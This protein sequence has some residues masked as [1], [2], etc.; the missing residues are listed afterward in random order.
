MH[1][2]PLDISCD[3]TH[4]TPGIHILPECGADI[5]SG[6]SDNRFGSQKLRS[7]ISKRKTTLRCLRWE[8]QGRN[9][10]HV[11]RWRFVFV[12]EYQKQWTQ[13]ATSVS[14]FWISFS[15]QSKNSPN[16]HVFLIYL[17]IY[18]Y[19]SEVG[20]SD[21]ARSTPPPRN[22]EIVS[23]RACVRQ[24]KMCGCKFNKWAHKMSLV[25][26]WRLIQHHWL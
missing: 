20:W 26:H 2:A 6:R 18:I 7:N 19:I 8:L 23:F 22:Q 14:L 15:S 25:Q 9:V 1:N 21:T 10:F 13:H 5:N 17:Y 11:F 4:R 12:W 3:W 16:P 24:W